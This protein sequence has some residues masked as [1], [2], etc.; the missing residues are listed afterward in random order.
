MNMRVIS[1]VFIPTTLDEMNDF[2]VIWER[3]IL[4]NN[5]LLYIEC[6]DNLGS[7]IEKEKM[8]DFFIDRLKWPVIVS[9]AEKRRFSV[10]DQFAFE[11]KK[12][13]VEEQQE[14][15]EKLIGDTPYRDEISTVASH[16]DLNFKDIQMCCSKVNSTKN[17]SLWDICRSHTNSS[18]G[19]LA[20]KI[21]PS[22]GAQSLILPEREQSILKEI[23]SH[24]KLRSVVYQDWGLLQNSAR[25]QGISVLFAGASGTGKTTAA[26]YLALKLRLDLYRID[27]SAIVSKY[28]GE[29][30]KNLQKIF[31]VAEK[32]GAILLFDEAD[33]LFAKRTQVNDSHDRHANVEVSYLL[34]RIESFRGLAILTSNFK[35]SIDKAFLRR[36][37]FIIQFP[38]P[39]K[40]ER[41]LIWRAMLPTNAPTQALD[42]DKLAQLNVAGGNI[43]NITM[44]ACFYAAAS[45]ESLQMKH[46]L[47]SSRDEYLK[48]EKNLSESE[49]RS[50][51]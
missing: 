9:S 37:R 5:Y 51:V 47:K 14:H 26:E 21:V 13:S 2:I 42:F 11:V 49:I 40:A 6:D 3:E 7:N 44:N 1:S 38:F 23:I 39:S 43:R 10:N 35:E 18:T 32:S 28:I 19:N 33:A 24:V 27:L 29:T 50:W 25:G 46:Y 17:S 41:E 16:F 8:V 45:Q 30:E 48:L 4:L 34:Q 12:P 36:L 15:W 31:A 22:Q 20:E